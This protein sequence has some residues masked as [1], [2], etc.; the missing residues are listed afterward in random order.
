MPVYEVIHR[1][2]I[3]SSIAYHIKAECAADAEKIS[4]KFQIGDKKLP[5]GVKRA[6]AD[7]KVMEYE[8]SI[9]YCVR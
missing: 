4:K 2:T 3:C 5:K 9:P 6:A 1:K 8:Q 7:F